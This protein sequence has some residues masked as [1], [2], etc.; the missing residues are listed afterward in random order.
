MLYA[1]ICR[2]VVSAHSARQKHRSQHRDYLTGQT[3]LLVLGG[4]LTDEDNNPTGSLYIVN[5]EDAE[6]AKKFSDNDPFAQQG[7]FAEV[8]IS[9]MRKTHWHPES[10]DDDPF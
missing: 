4:A 10:A 1:V 3:Q 6:S 9:P 5:V 8:S 7:V 2:D